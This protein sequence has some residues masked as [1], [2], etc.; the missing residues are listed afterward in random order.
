MQTGQRVGRVWFRS[1]TFAA[2]VAQELNERLN[3]LDCAKAIG[4]HP[5]LLR[6]I[7]VV[8]NEAWIEESR[9]LGAQDSYGR[10]SG[11]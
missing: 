9:N 8:E 11:V 7:I 10:Y 5:V 4:Q 1:E 2:K 6:Y 3:G